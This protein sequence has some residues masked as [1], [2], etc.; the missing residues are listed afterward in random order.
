[1]VLDVF[2]D[3]FL[4]IFITNNVGVLLKIYILIN[5]WN[6][7][8]SGGIKKNN[9]LLLVIFRKKTRERN[10]VYIFYH[11]I[12][13]SWL[14]KLYVELI[15][16]ENLIIFILFTLMIFNFSNNDK[17]IERAKKTNRSY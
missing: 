16:D 4:K 11:S 15:L 5:Y 14:S 3:I 12:S 10:F 1:M 9:E 8:V 7:F 13:S 6:F 2:L 17:K